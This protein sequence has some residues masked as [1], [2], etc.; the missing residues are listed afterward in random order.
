MNIT[1]IGAGNV[2]WHLAQAL[3]TAGHRIGAVYSRS[4]TSAQQL[5]QLLPG[6]EVLTGLDLRHVAAD[7]VLLAVP[8]AALASVAAALQVKPGILVAHTSGSQS[9]GILQPVIGARLGVFYPLQTFSRQ[10]PVDFAQVPFLLEAQNAHTLQELRQLALSISPNVQQVDS[11]AR[12]KLHLAAV[13]ACNFTNHLLGISRQLL[14]QAQLPT[15][16]LQALIQETVTKALQ[17]DPFRVQT[18]PAIR[19][20][21]N[22]I[23]THLQMLQHHPR[24]QALYQ[25]LTESIQAGK[26]LRV[27]S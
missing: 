12:K 23:A 20:D 27:K 25:A 8:D 11:E 15:D 19:G 16:L 1:I 22:V 26:E 5:A 10:K 3:Q 7:V 17:N 9:L 21:E 4:A 6:A 14:Q 2:A 13:F 18:G 24:Y